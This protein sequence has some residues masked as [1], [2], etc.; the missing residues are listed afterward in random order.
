[1]EGSDD[2]VNSLLDYLFTGDYK[3]M[4]GYVKRKDREYGLDWTRK[5]LPQHRFD[6][7]VI[8]LQSHKT[9]S[10]ALD[11]SSA[12]KTSERGLIIGKET[13]DPA[14]SFSNSRSFQMPNSKIPFS[15][16]TG[17]FAMPGASYDG[18]NGIIPDIIY[19]VEQLGTLNAERIN[20]LYKMATYKCRMYFE[21]EYFK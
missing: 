6:G 4:F 3:V 17:F 19:N 7:N 11:F 12:I 16:A 13:R 8:V 21:K 18:K 15:C 2:L 9:A 20:S 5:N 10:A 14:Y 1:M